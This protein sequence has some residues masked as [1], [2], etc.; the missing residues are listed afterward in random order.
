MIVP[1]EIRKCVAFIGIEKAN[2]ETPLVGTVFFLSR[3]VDDI[4]WTY[5]VTAK[6]VIEQIRSTGVESASIRVNWVGDESDKLKW[7][8]ISL[9][10]W[11]FHPTDDSIDV[12]VFAGNLPDSCD[13]FTYSISRIVTSELIEKEFVGHGTEVFI[14]GLFVKHFGQEKNIPIVRIGNIAAMPEERIDFKSGRFDAYLI[15]ARSIGG[16]SGAP[17]FANLEKTYVERGELRHLRKGLEHYLLGMMLG[18]WDAVSNLDNSKAVPT[19]IQNVNMGI[20]I[21]VPI[22]KIIEVIN[23]HFIAKGGPE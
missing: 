9:S 11:K 10:D 21:V 8:R 20:G 22:A 15:E 14:T 18:H 1:N 7:L 5:F 17:V 13:L 6:H 12:A 3:Q 19:N 16:L 2:G 23:Y 4:I